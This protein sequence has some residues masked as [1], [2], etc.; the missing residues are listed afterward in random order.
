MAGT[1]VNKAMVDNRLHH[2]IKKRQSPCTFCI[3]PNDVTHPGRARSLNLYDNDYLT[4]SISNASIGT[5]T[6]DGFRYD[7]TLLLNPSVG[8]GGIYFN[9]VNANGSLAFANLTI[10]N[11]AADDSCSCYYCPDD[12]FFHGG[13]GTFGGFFGCGK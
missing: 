10:I 4:I 7:V 11:L 8:L 9:F 5:T 2:S 1:V 3:A 12:L 13:A 6:S